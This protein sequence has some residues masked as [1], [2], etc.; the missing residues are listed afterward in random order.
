MSYNQGFT[1]LSLVGTVET[2]KGW[3]H[4]HSHFQHLRFF[5]KGLLVAQVP[6]EKSGEGNPL[7]WISI[8]AQTTRVRNRRPHKNWLWK[9]A[10]ILS[11][12]KRQESTIGTG[13]LRQNQS[14]IPLD[15]QAAYPKV[16]LNRHQALLRWIL[17]CVVST[18]TAAC[19]LWLRLILTVSQPE[20]RITNGPITI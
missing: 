14:K 13:A 20:M 2:T 1:T 16:D 4:S 11:T 3:P 18:C 5:W 19:A 17:L 8:P 12:R 9:L 7:F 10:G 15:S 6:P